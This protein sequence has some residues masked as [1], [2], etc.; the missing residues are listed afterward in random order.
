MLNNSS[1]I[2][3]NTI[4]SLGNMNGMNNYG[5]NGNNTNNLGFGLGNNF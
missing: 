5:N 2:L 1:S 3:G 4:G